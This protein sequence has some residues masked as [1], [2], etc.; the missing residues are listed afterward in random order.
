MKHMN[1]NT[2]KS[3]LSK[4]YVIVALIIAILALLLYLILSGGAEKIQKAISSQD[5][6]AHTQTPEADNKTPES[7]QTPS[8]EPSSSADTEDPA[9]TAEASAEPE[10]T[11]S[12]TA[13]ITDDI[14]SDDSLTKIVSPSRTIASS[15]V[16]ANLVMPDVPCILDENQN[17]MRADAAAALEEMFAAAGNDGYE[18]FLIS[19]YRSY[20]FQQML[21]KYWVEKKGEAYADELDTKPGGSEHQLGLAANIGTTDGKCEL[22]VCFADTGAYAWLKEN[23]WKYGYIERYPESKQDITGITFSP[24]NFRYVGKDAAE[25]IYQS[26]KTMEEYY[27]LS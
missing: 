2:E 1:K 12:A 10:P 16:P 24:W 21:R 13:E 5:K 23:S 6:P 17:L 4:V 25:R 26:G 8:A 9:E 3:F 14:E 27:G 15:Y 20:E 11:P 18:L 7:T 19:G 22:N